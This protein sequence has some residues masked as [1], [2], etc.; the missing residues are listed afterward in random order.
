M[1]F[2]HEQNR[3]YYEQDGRMLA[4]ITFPAFLERGE[5]IVNIDHTFV[6]EILRGQ[7]VAGQ[8]MERTVAS[9]RQTQRK[10]LVTCSYA[11]KWFTQHEDAQ[12]VLA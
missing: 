12:D 3:I 9:L 4:E 10:A 1:P 7:G 6:D 2:I 5:N 8:L 11:R